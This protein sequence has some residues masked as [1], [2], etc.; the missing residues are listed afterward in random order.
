ME[1]K[2]V[3]E[4]VATELA[5]RLGEQERKDIKDSVCVSITIFQPIPAGGH[6]GCLPFA[7][8]T[9]AVLCS[10]HRYITLLS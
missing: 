9:E 8:L 3:L 7:S 5:N 2:Y 1:S 4:I 6:S 10:T